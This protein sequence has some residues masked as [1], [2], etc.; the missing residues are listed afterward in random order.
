MLD[1]AYEKSKEVIR[2]SSTNHGL[3]ASGGKGGYDAVWSRDSMI[4]LI[5]ASLAGE[6]FKEVFKQ[7]LITLAKHQS[8]K[9][10][11]PNAVDKFSKRKK[12]VDYKSIDSTLWFLIGEYIYKKRYK[13]NSLF[14]KFFSDKKKSKPL[15]KRVKEFFTQLKDG[16][17]GIKDRLLTFLDS[18]KVRA[19]PPVSFP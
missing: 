7:S 11:I 1:E 18:L 15:K 13:D 4:S 5:G 10:Q 6:E 9:G 8:E 16:L 2:K 17:T 3:F 12:H 14:N 19:D